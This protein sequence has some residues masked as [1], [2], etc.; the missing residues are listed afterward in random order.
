MSC[1]AGSCFIEQKRPRRPA[2]KASPL[3]PVRPRR[4][5]AVAPSGCVGDAPGE[6]SLPSGCA[7][8][9]TCGGGGCG[10]CGPACGCAPCRAAHHGDAQPSGL[11]TVAMPTL[12][13]PARGTAPRLAL[14]P[15][16]LVVRAL[17]WDQLSDAERRA[18]V[19]LAADRAIDA[20]RVRPAG[21]PIP[22]EVLG[23][24]SQEDW[25][26]MS[27]EER[28]LAPFDLPGA[29]ARMRQRRGQGGGT[30]ATADA[31]P[32]W[33]REAGITQQT[34]GSM[35]TSEREAARREHVAA[36][37]QGL[38]TV[39][40]IVTQGTAIVNQIL[41][42]E[43]ERDVARIT[44]QASTQNAQVTADAMRFV[45]ETNRQR[46]ELEL[47][48]AQARASGNA[49]QAEQFQ[50]AIQAIQ[51]AQQQAQGQQ[52]AS[53]AAL[54]ESMRQKSGMSTG[55]MIAAGVGGVALLGG[56]VYLATRKR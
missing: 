56:I 53:L 38:Q 14:R 30:P 44:A 32:A 12:R 10:G 42:G 23:Q 16:G 46:A 26:A 20:L 48:A 1:S 28:A 55:T 35:N 31:L 5:I 36:S 40:T 51:V 6:T 24:V 13:S 7:D 39:Q 18:L 25:D 22:L 37:G 15:S 34:W 3:G 45:S 47:A 41:R 9:A 2:A 49:G 27:N 33:A 19:G 11:V 17:P 21:I 4:R 8:G 29:L 43:L 50:Q 54:V 52:T